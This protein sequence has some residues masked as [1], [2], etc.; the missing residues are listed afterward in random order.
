MDLCTRD[1]TGVGAAIA[2]GNQ[3]LKGKTAL[4]VQQAKIKNRPGRSGTQGP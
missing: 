2:S 1:E 4:L 3:E